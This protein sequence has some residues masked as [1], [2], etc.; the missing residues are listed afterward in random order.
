MSN[1]E[2]HYRYAISYL[3]ILVI[4][5]IGFGL[6]DVPNLVDKVSF[7][8]TVTSLVLGIVAIFYTFVSANK[9][10]TQL[11]KLIE[12]NHDISN[13][14]TRIG[15]TAKALSDQLGTIPPRFDSV[16]AKLDTLTQSALVSP[17]PAAQT[18]INDSA[19]PATQQQDAEPSLDD[20]KHFISDLKYAGMF[21]LYLLSKAQKN[22]IKINEELIK[23]I[24]S[25]P[26]Y[27]VFGVFD[28]T[29]AAG[30]I[31]TTYDGGVISITSVSNVFSEHLEPQVLHIVQLLE[32]GDQESVL[33]RLVDAVDR[34]IP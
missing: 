1:R 8:L 14:S 27:Y 30:F 2:L 33:K 6:Y 19:G 16:D 21:S 23:K 17:T 9:Q 28:A 3:I 12:T 22:G 20:L 10:D 34:E 31:K 15:S 24:G 32:G 29:E 7:A 13:A 26:F 4:A 5:S 18:Q 11:T 25:I